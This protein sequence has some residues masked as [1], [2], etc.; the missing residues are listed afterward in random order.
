MEVLLVLVV[1]VPVVWTEVEVKLAWT[2][3]MGGAVGDAGYEF[4][5]VTQVVDSK[6]SFAP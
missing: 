3:G 4:E 6:W 2:G 5:L 1:L